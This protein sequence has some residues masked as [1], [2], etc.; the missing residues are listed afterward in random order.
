MT[1]DEIWAGDVFGRKVEAEQLIGYIETVASR[2]SLREDSYGFVLALDAPYGQGKSFFLRRFAEHIR[3]SHPIAFVDAWVDDLEDEPLVALAAT[4]DEALSPLADKSAGLAEKIATFRDKA[5]AVAKL[6]G[7]GLLKRG[8][9]LVVMSAAADA[10][11]NVVTGASDLRKDLG[12][13]ALEDSAKDLEAAAAE[14]LRP[15]ATPNMD[16][17][18]KRF[19]EGRNAVENLKASLR[20]I[21][22]HLEEE[23]T[24]PPPIV[25]VVDELDRC[26]PSYA[27]KFME[28]VKHLF[29]VPGLVFVLG[30]HEGQLG[31]SISATYGPDFDGH[32]YLR[33]FF[34]RRYKL[35]EAPLHPLVQMIFRTRD[36]KVE[37]LIS[38]ML[39]LGSGRAEFVDPA[40]VVSLNMELYGLN[41][42][43]AY[44]VAD[45]LEVCLSLTGS[46]GL[47]LPL[48]M[49]MIVSHLKGLDGLPTVMNGGHWRYAYFDNDRNE[50]KFVEADQVAIILRD[51][52]WLNDQQLTARINGTQP[53]WTD[54]LLAEHTF[55]NSSVEGDLAKPRGYHRL[56]QTVD[57]FN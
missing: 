21:V 10:I 1:E 39:Q 24:Y 33:R 9:S 41:A 17:R 50:I 49:P 16:E 47:V 13:D 3:L 26:R 8:L 48:L 36:L 30:V 57:R 20:A 2:P 54:E 25:I 23:A 18:I 5:G 42:R 51:G 37:R 55:K 52:A 7:V 6:A 4:L 40:L 44:Q 14:G 22:A 46:D 29:D 27:V 12:K 56:L 31:H 43:D 15:L 28:E 35:R 45:M 32:A 34:N 53:T 11:G 38:P 19:R